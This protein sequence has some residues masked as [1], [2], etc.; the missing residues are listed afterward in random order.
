[1][2]GQNNER[3]GKKEIEKEGKMSVK[4]KKKKSVCEEE[5][6]KVRSATAEERRGINHCEFILC[7]LIYIFSL[8]ARV[9]GGC[10]SPR[11]C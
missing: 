8:V 5:N 2:C 1:M 7:I 11:A 9:V 10:T 3:K 6:G 4:K